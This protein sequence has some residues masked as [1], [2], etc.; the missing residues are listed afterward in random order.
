MLQEL[1]LRDSAY[2]YCVELSR[3]DLDSRT[4]VLCPLATVLVATVSGHPSARE[5][6][7]LR[8]GFNLFHP[9]GYDGLR[10]I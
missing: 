5:A 3:P 7:P 6:V 1:K 9:V 10:Q 4:R 8:T 2:A